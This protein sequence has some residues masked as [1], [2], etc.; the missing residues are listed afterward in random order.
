MRR[1]RVPRVLRRDR[2][3]H[4][5]SGDIADHYTHIGDEMIEDMLAALTLRWQAAVTAR[6]RIDRARGCE[7]RSTV[8]ALD[9]WLA[10]FR[11]RPGEIRLPWAL[12]PANRARPCPPWTNGWPCSGSAREKSGSHRPRIEVDSE[13]FCL[14]GAGGFE[15]P[16][17]RL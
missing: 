6:A 15:P 10:L 2:L 16:A 12:P 4:G 11:E 17:P 8:P 9:E 5:P 3:G 14:V 13:V 7:P 1:D